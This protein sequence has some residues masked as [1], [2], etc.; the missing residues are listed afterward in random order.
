MN[1]RREHG[2]YFSQGISYLAL[3]L[4]NGCGM[5]LRVRQR[6]SSAGERRPRSLNFRFHYSSVFVCK[7]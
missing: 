7:T 5:I 4:L 2:W 6:T 1:L 3:E